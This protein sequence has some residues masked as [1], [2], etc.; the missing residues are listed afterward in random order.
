ME[1]ENK[2][3]NGNGNGKIMDRIRKMM[4]LAMDPRTPVHEAESAQNMAATLMAKYGIEEFEVIK[5]EKIL[6]GNFEETTITDSK[7]GW[8]SLLAAGLARLF[9]CTVCY[10]GYDGKILRFYGYPKD[11]DNVRFLFNYLQFHIDSKADAL[12]LKGEKKKSW[13]YGAV[14]GVRT[15][16]DSVYKKKEAAMG[17]GKELMVVKQNNARKQ[18]RTDFPDLRNV[19]GTRPKNHDL[20]SKGFEYGKTIGINKGLGGGEKKER[21]E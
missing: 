2:E 19:K 11:L 14:M 8:E 1:P 15:V 3:P 6:V 21:I 12:K 9:D 18:M 7:K 4:I 5:Q 13:A 20:Y 16:L 10:I 17:T